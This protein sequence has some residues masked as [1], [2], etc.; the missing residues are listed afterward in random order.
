MYIYKTTNLI[1]DKVYI[2]KSEKEFD[3]S[4]YG[5]GIL[6]WKAIKK[7]GIENFKVEVIETCETTVFLN[8][9]EIYWIDQY[10]DHSYNIAKGG[11]G[12]DT[13]QNHPDKEEIIKR[14]NASVSK[15]LA[16]HSVSEETRRKISEKKKGQ[17]LSEEQKKKISETAKRNGLSGGDRYS[18]R[19][20]EQLEETKKKLSDAAKRNGLGGNTWINLSDEEKQSRSKKLSESAKGKKVSEETRGKITEKLK[21]RKLSEE[22]RKKI[23]ETIK[24]KKENYGKTI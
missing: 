23:S 21:G 24:S 20:E 4:Y 12:G 14:R 16:G 13:I 8:E 7:Y 1:N 17:T 18:N 15:S 11:T 10:K 5:S 22:T 9:R 3:G 2:G 19:S 6:L